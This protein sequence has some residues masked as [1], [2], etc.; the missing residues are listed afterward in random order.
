M[1]L[2]FFFLHCLPLFLLIIQNFYFN[3]F[4]LLTLFQQIPPP[5][6]FGFRFLDVLPPFGTFRYILN[7]S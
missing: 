1:L 7:M 5:L 2:H 6:F 3:Y 4:Y